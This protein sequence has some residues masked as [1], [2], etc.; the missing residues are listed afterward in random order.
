MRQDDDREKEVTA[1]GLKYNLLTRY[2]SFVAIDTR[3]RG[4]GN[5]E[6]IRQPLPL[7]QDVSDYAV[8]GYTSSG[9][10][11]AGRAMKCAQS[12][13]ILQSNLER[14]GE[15]LVATPS[16]DEVVTGRVEVGEV[17][18]NPGVTGVGVD[19][20]RQAVAGIVEAHLVR[21][22]SCYTAELS[23]DPGLG[24]G[25]L[26]KLTIGPD[27]SVTKVEFLK[28]ELN[29]AVRE[30]VERVFGKLSFAGVTGHQVVVY[31]PL[32]FNP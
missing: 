24:G 9:L 21:I 8:G 31:V 26:V 17:T 22:D 28:N 4:D 16:G 12:R 3:V 18:T 2:T 15:E 23:G 5:A 11:G 19:P 27:G 30:C 13:P 29:T 6:V 25:M 20:F 1:L 32:E 10:G 7:P 14:S